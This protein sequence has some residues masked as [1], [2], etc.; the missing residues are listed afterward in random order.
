VPASYFLGNR[1]LAV[2]PPLWWSDMQQ[3]F[4]PL[5]FLCPHCGE[6]WGRLAMSG[7]WTAVRR[8]CERCGKS[9]YGDPGSFLHPWL[10]SPTLSTAPRELLLYEARLRLRSLPHD[11][12]F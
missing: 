8:G 12:V 9:D 4:G 6:V 2:G 5:A 1:L 3:C 7:E 10:S 11:V